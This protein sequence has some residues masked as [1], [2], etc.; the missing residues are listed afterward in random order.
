MGE[1]KEFNIHQVTEEEMDDDIKMSYRIGLL[2]ECSDKFGDAMRLSSDHRE[3]F[4]ASIQDQ[5]DHRI[6]DLVSQGD[7]SREEIRESFLSFVQFLHRL[8]QGIE[9]VL[10]DRNKNWCKAFNDRFHIGPV[11]LEAKLQS[12]GNELKNKDSHQEDW[13]DE[14][15]EDMFKI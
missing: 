8:A 4:L 7:F 11:D 13:P 6:K 15:D 5:I 1:D 12:K 3:D 9:E 14:L 10:N 2:K